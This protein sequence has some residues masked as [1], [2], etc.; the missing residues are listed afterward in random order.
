[1]AEIKFFKVT[2]LPGTLEANAFYFVSN[3]QYAES[4]ITDNAGAAKSIGNSTMIEEV[5]ADLLGGNRFRVVDD[6]TARDNLITGDQP[7]LVLVADAT[8]DATVDT[9]GALYAW[10]PEAGESGEFRKVSEYESMDIDFS[11]I[12]INWSQLVNG[13]T[14]DVADID[15]AV[16]KRHEHTNKTV[17]DDL[18]DDG[19]DNLTY[20]DNPI[21]MLWTQSNW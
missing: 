13:P 6:I 21:G 17:L 19:N 14:S 11:S 7:F 18:G 3:S 10:K 1:M 8:A 2:S 15:D 5:A 16:T 4:Y 20:K 9:G 12:D